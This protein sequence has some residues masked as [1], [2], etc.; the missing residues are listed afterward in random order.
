MWTTSFAT[1]SI[2]ASATFSFSSAR[3]LNF[4][5]VRFALTSASFFVNSDNANISKNPH[6]AM[7]I[8]ARVHSVSRHRMDSLKYS[9]MSIGAPDRWFRREPRWI[10]R[11]LDVSWAARI[12]C[13]S[14][15]AVAA[16]FRHSSNRNTASYPGKRWRRSALNNSSYTSGLS[17]SG[18]CN[19]MFM[20][21]VGESG[22]NWGGCTTG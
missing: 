5:A 11:D 6:Q 15:S 17:V 14:F 2:W 3:S 7:T 4:H 1:S 8:P 12:V 13:A 20:A 21:I 18:S 16:R 22:W 10:T 9:W 19:W